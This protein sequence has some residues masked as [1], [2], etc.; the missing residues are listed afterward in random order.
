VTVSRRGLLLGA[1]G[2]A[3]LGVVGGYE[4]VEHNVLP[5]R[6]RLNTM[7]GRND[8]RPPVT[9]S[10]PGTMVSGTF[11]SRARAGTE[12]GWTI[13][14]PPGSQPGDLLPVCVA[15]HGRDEAHAWVFDTLALQFFLA[16]AVERRGVPPFAIASVDGGD[17][18]NWHRRASGDDPQAM[19]TDEFV[20][21]LARRGLA[22]DPFGLW[23][24]SLGGY[25]ALLLASELGPKHI[26]AVV[27]S[28]PALWPAPEDTA[29]DVFDDPADFERNNIFT[30]EAQ[31][32]G[33]PLR[34]DIGDNDS[35][36]PAVERFISELSSPPAGG[37]TDGFHDAAYWTRVAPTE[38]S[39]LG[40]HLG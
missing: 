36:Q 17:A 19:V 5:G 32:D 16:D 40:N 2:A 39:F 26:A 3:V 13:A 35:F 7:L 28:S 29:P 27:A 9:G 12:V 24:W 33:I 6:I 37:V 20:P 22:T 38:I 1:G 30:R 15:M 11:R 25:G 4:L 23:G 21:L 8:E 31:L 14:Y 18:T 34:I 10:R